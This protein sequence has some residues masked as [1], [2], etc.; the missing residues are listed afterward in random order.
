VAHKKNNGYV[1]MPS[2]FLIGIVIIAIQQTR[3]IVTACTDHNNLNAYIRSLEVDIIQGT[4]LTSKVNS[5][6]VEYVLI[7]AQTDN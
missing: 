6:V 3:E 1:T 7:Q 4:T 5:W 2:I